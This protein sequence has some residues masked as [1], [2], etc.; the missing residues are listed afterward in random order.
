MSHGTSGSGQSLLLGQHFHPSS[1]AQRRHLARRS[2]N[3]P[4]TTHPPSGQ[5][6]TFWQRYVYG[7]FPLKHG[8]EGS[9]E[10]HLHVGTVP[11]T[12]HLLHPYSR[13]GT[14]GLEEFKSVLKVSQRL[15]TCSPTWSPEVLLPCPPACGAQ[16]QQRRANRPRRA[17]GSGWWGLFQEPSPTLPPGTRAG[18]GK[19]AGGIRVFP[20]EIKSEVKNNNKNPIELLNLSKRAICYPFLHDMFSSTSPGAHTA[21]GTGRRRSPVSSTSVSGP[22]RSKGQTGNE[23]QDQ[24]QMRAS[25]MS[26]GVLQKTEGAHLRESCPRREHYSGQKTPFRLDTSHPWNFICRRADHSR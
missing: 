14:G 12:Y 17:N 5:L 25:Q 15:G 11:Y 20:D 10:C 9:R 19:G 13:W 21:L 22:I 23:K 24:G 2:A 16:W 3:S 18:R 7:C 8:L 4:K 1:R 26:G 6:A